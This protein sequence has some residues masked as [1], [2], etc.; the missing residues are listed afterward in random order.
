MANAQKWTIR[1]MDPD[2]LAMLCE[3]RQT[4]GL[5][6]GVLLSQAVKQCFAVQSGGNRQSNDLDEIPDG[7]N[8]RSYIAPNE[9]EPWDTAR[10]LIIS[11]T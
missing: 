10:R 2:A 3:A 1:N 4:S 9:E 8:C 5:S 6:F 7:D 11:M